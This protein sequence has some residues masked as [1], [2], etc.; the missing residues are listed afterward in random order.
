MTGRYETSRVAQVEAAALILV[1]PLENRYLRDSY[2]YHQV[3][4]I[5]NYRNVTVEGTL[6]TSA[7][8]GTVGGVLAFRASGIVTVGAAGLIHMNR[9]GLPRFA[10]K[11]EG[12]AQ[13]ADMT[14]RAMRP[15]TWT[16]GVASGITEALAVG[17]AFGGRAAGCKASQALG[18]TPKSAA[19]VPHRDVVRG[20]W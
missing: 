5:P 16:C 14:A 6:S 1:S 12:Q 10:G 8:G 2:Q 9:A 20:G 17:D 13:M 4:R 18:A 7:W 15:G 3:V 19:A 11:W